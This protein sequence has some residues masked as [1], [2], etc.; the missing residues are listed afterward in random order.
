MLMIPMIETGAGCWT[1]IH[2]LGDW[3]T[4]MPETHWLVPGA[5]WLVPGAHWLAPR[6]HW[7]VP[8]AHW[9][10]P[11]IHWLVPGTR[12]D[13]IR[14][15]SWQ[16][17]GDAPHQQQTPMLEILLVHGGILMQLWILLLMIHLDCH[18]VQKPSYH[19]ALKP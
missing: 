10:V 7:L 3:T 6:I 5:H 12:L 1:G 8:G 13:E 9:L 19:L 15:L 4:H 11:R 16:Q 14:W 17:P 18:V 2:M